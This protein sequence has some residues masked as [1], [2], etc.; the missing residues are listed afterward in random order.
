MNE[1]RKEFIT[2]IA[3]KNNV[4]IRGHT[5]RCQKVDFRSIGSMLRKLVI[6][7]LGLVDILIFIF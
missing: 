4:V 6:M 2:A 1:V 7:L 5:D 3:Y